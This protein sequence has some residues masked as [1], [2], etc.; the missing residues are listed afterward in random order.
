MLAEHLGDARPQLVAHHVIAKID[1]RRESF[2]VRGAMALDHE[3]IEAEKD[4][5]IDLARIHLVPYGSAR[6]ASTQI[7]DPGGQGT[8]HRAAQVPSHLIG[9]PLGRLPG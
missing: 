5:T 1:P 7:P 2:G 8:A 3:P 9:G 6:L 4:P